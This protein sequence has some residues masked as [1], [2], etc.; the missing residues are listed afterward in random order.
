MGCIGAYSTVGGVAILGGRG[1]DCGVWHRMRGCGND[2]R[3]IIIV[4]KC[5]FLV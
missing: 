5:F 2:A 4:C 1:I 3:L